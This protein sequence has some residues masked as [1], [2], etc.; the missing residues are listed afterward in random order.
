MPKEITHWTLAA[1]L[2]EA[3]PENSLFYRPIHLFPNLFFLGAIAPDIPFY[4]LAGPHMKSARKLG[5]FLHKGDAHALMPVLAF[6]DQDQDPAARAFAA[7]VVCHILADTMFHPLVYYFSGKEG[8]H[9]GAT[10]RHRQ[11][12]T[13][14]DIHLYCRSHPR[15]SLARVVRQLE[16]SKK[17]RN[18]FL[19]SL[20]Q[21]GSPGQE[22][23]LGTALNFFPDYIGFRGVIYKETIERLSC[24]VELKI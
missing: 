6:L 12:E 24:M 21:V 16:V 22:A 5:A 19:G 18:H 20:F 15:E 2:A 9:A 4:Y 10:A 1:A 11:F 8:I 23:S 3:L 17:R 7:G 14:L 13:A